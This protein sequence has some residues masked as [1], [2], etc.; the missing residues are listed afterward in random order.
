MQIGMLVMQY[1]CMFV[2]LCFR[3]IELGLGRGPAGECPPQ[4]IIFKK[5]EIE[6]LAAVVL[7][8]VVLLF[9]RGFVIIMKFW[10]VLK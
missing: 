7:M 4:A 3:K 6:K 8:F 2:C 1:F 9:A 5:K 10:N